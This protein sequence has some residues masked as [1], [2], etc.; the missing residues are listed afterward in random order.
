MKEKK[1]S[2]QKFIHS[3]KKTTENVGLLL[4]RAGDLMVKDTEKAEVINAYLISLL[5]RAAIRNTR[6]V[7]SM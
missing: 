3:R 5:S 7:W 4:N 1:K 2:F 6:S